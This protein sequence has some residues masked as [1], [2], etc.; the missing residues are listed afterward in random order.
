MDFERALVVFAHP[1]DAEFLCGGT[2]ARW[3]DAGT[4]VDYACATD[5]SAG[6]N[7][8]D[9]GREEIAAVRADELRAA[10]DVLGVKEVRFLGFVDGALRPDLELRK[11]VTREVRRVRPD[12]I[13]APDPSTLWS[14]RSYI[15]HPDHRAVG[16]AVLAVVACDAPTRPQFPEL[17]E[18][19]L[20]PFT[21]PALW[22]STEH[23][24]ADTKI[25]IGS[26]ID[27]K[28]EAVQA[29]TSQ[30][31]NMGDFDVDGK[32]RQWARAIAKGSETE[33][34]EAF[35]TFDLED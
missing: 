11:A 1:D 34:A 26:T 23:R 13:V 28:I 18:E 17:V 25:D 35:R 3:A 30:I 7:G 15:N 19:G 10:A 5:G 16:E 32:I 9:R 22:L 33:Y 29:H 2:I 27:R 21:V 12:V 14:G 20:E 31:A 8:P 6:W 24:E 4:E